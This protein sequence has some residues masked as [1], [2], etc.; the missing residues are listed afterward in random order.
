[1]SIH[2]DKPLDIQNYQQI[3]DAFV[4]MSG[5]F[6]RIR[7][8]AS[9]NR[10]IRRMNVDVEA[11]RASGK[12][13]A[14]QTYIARRVIDANIK[15]E[16]P[17]FIAYLKQ[18]RRL[19]VF[20]C[21][22]DAT[23]NVD[24]LETQFTE[25]MQYNGWEI[26]YFKSL[27]GAQLHGWDSVEIEYDE[28][29]PLKVGISHIGH[30]NLV[31]PIDCKQLGANDMLA[32]R[33][34]VTPTQLRTF[35]RYNFSQ[36]MVTR[37]CATMGAERTRLIVIHKVF[38]KDESGVVYVGWLNDTLDSWLSAP[39]KLDLGRRQKVT[40]TENVPQQ[41]ADGTVVF[42]PQP[43]EEWQPIDETEFP[44]KLL[45]YS[46]TEQ[47]QI[48]EQIGRAQ[49]DDADQEAQTSLWT[50]AVN[51]ALRA[52]NVYGSPEQ[53]ESQGG[54]LSVVDVELIP[55]RIYNKKI[56]W[57]SPPWPEGFVVQL[58]QA[59]GVAKQA[60]T[61]S[62]DFAVNNRQDSRK[63][64]TEIGAAEK[65]AALL[66]GVQVMLWAA[67]LRDIFN[68]AWP[69]VQNLALRDEIKLLTVT[70]EVPINPQFPEMTQS[71]TE[72]NKQV[73]GQVFDIKPAGDIDVVQRAEKLNRMQ[74]IWPIIS[75]T[76]LAQAFLMD[77]LK[78]MFPQDVARYAQMM[79]QGD[80]KNQLLQG[81]LGIMQEI[82]NTP[83]DQIA[84]SLAGNKQQFQQMAQQIQQ[85]LQT[86]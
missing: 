32:R 23:I 16:Q 84:D 6:D 48:T 36:D 15:N 82:S 40:I 29:K 66:Q 85:V 41:L 57:W 70:Q 60:E 38:I 71:V 17:P 10:R 53:D 50:S 62:V 55:D 4:L 27:D 30:E 37:L 22:S 42:I 54:K 7:T 25:G 64:A 58:S 43:R 86:P 76:P 2:A 3:K 34:E 80:K 20:K 13:R 81:M 59:M 68:F 19:A 83:P 56:N 79:A 49:L 26:D 47:Q 31:M 5:N 65:Q 75:T 44:L 9:M 67:W 39:V 24:P 18:S 52:S 78:E 11:L 8:Q 72:N 74:T 28:S 14:D 21:L 73:L 77:I 61:G 35:A 33:F 1:M 12:L 63:T 46:L 45:S 69:I 51:G